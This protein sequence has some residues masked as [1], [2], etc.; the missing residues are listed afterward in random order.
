MKKA[1]RL[2]R[3]KSDQEAADFWDAH[4]IV[5]FWHLLK[6]AKVTLRRPVRHFVLLQ[7]GRRMTMAEFQKMRRA[8]TRK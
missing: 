7:D 4:S 6:P 1:R 2:P 3:F 8:A 5:P